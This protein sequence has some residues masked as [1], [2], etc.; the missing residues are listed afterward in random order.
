MDNIIK[1]GIEPRIVGVE[2]EPIEIAQNKHI[3]VANIPKS[4]ISPHRVIFNNH[5]HFYIRTTSGKHKL[6]VAELRVAF[7]IT[8][9]ATQKIK[10]F[11][12]ER[13]GNII[14]GQTP[15]EMITNKSY[16]LL[17]MVP[18]NSLTVGTLYDINPSQYDKL[19][20]MYASS[21][22]TSFNFDGYIAF[23]RDSNR[24]VYSYTQLFK[25]GIIESLY[26]D[27]LREGEKDRFLNPNSFEPEILR[28]LNKYLTVQ[29]ATGV[30]LPIFIF[31]TF[32]GCK[33]FTIYTERVRFDRH[34]LK[35]HRDILYLP[36]VLVESF[37]TE[38]HEF[39]RP[40]LDSIWN[41]CGYNCCPNY[42]DDGNYVL[43]R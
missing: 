12:E 29:K 15:F 17:H 20:P 26:A 10:N 40:I 42:D 22:D 27:F 43:S 3:L 39:I 21:W 14:S 30:Q 23:S 41:S 19:I 24:Q 33:D 35:F 34:I 28:S 32:I 31:L 18:L 16:L 36:E 7:N 11:R 6:D 37:N 9:T 25:N 2:Y 8:D 4:W 13:L 5:G 38:P 1:T